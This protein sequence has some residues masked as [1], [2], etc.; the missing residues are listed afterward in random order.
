MKIAFHKLLPADW[1]WALDHSLRSYRVRLAHEGDL[2]SVSVDAVTVTVIRLC[3]GERVVMPKC[4]AD[5]PAEFEDADDNGALYFCME[6][7]RRET[8][9]EAKL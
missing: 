9:G 5:N 8:C 1:V 6:D 7:C 4:D 2:A 3:D